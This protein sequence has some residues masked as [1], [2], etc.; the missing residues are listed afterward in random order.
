[1]LGQLKA[2][3]R[4]LGGSWAGRYAS[5][6]ALPRWGAGPPQHSTRSS[7]CPQTVAQTTDIQMA[8]AGTKQTL[9][10]LGPTDSDMV[11]GSMGL[12]STVAQVT[13]Q[14]HIIRLFLTVMESPVPH[15][16]MVHKPYNFTFSST[17]LPHSYSSE[18]HLPGLCPLAVLS[19][20][21]ALPW[22]ISI[23]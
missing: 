19:P 2:L 3:D 9:A 11:A 17:S 7:A 14:A 13:V 16:L 6:L 23:F 22:V 4:G 15:F 5:S 18:C 1:M 8:F 20:V 12:D 10:P 21:T